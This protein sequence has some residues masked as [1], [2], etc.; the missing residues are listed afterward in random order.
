[1]CHGHCTNVSLFDSKVIQ[2]HDVPFHKGP[3]IELYTNLIERGAFTDARYLWMNQV[4]NEPSVS[5]A[6][7]CNVSC[8][9]GQLIWN[10][11]SDVFIHFR[12]LNMLQFYEVYDRQLCSKCG[13]DAI[14]KRTGSP[15]VAEVDTGGHNQSAAAEDNITAD[16][17]QGNGLDSP[18]MTNTEEVAV[19]RASAAQECQWSDDIMKLEKL[20]CL[21]FHMKNQSRQLLSCILRKLTAEEKDDA[22]KILDNSQCTK[23]AKRQLTEIIVNWK[24][25]SVSREDIITLSSG[26]WLNDVIVNF[27]H[28]VCLNQHDMSLCLRHDIR[29]RSHAFSSFF[30]QRLFDTKNRNPALCNQYSFENVK[31]WSNKVP[32]KDKFNLKYILC[33]INL[34][35]VH[36]TLAVIYMEGKRIQYYDSLGKT[37]EAKLQGLFQYVRD[38]YKAKNSGKEM[39]V[40]E[41]MLISNTDTPQQSNGNW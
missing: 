4:A 9:S 14:N 28:H 15:I 39:D 40:S 21:L 1:M 25:D 13:Q 6:W 34:G 11:F 26:Q 5:A 19:S 37:D 10:C 33:P 16:L 31:R 35:N 23:L 32:G 24:S 36:W 20:T 8:K 2:L 12:T 7:M 17:A 27:F 41:W 3:S 29:R 30:V 18:S 38:E 22:F